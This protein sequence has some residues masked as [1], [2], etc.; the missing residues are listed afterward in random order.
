MDSRS[1]RVTGRARVREDGLPNP[2]DCG[3]LK[4]FLEGAMR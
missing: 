2:L 4:V 3:L 1:D